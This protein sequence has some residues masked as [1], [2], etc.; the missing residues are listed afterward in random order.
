MTVHDK[1]KDEKTAISLMQPWL[2]LMADWKETQRNDES[3]S[4]S[5]Q[6]R[7]QGRE[8]RK[9]GKETYMRNWVIHSVVNEIWNHN[10]WK[11]SLNFRSLGSQVTNF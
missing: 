3:T 1:K 4:C 2:G 9:P 11:D 10:H 7:E 6:N 8:G 5:G